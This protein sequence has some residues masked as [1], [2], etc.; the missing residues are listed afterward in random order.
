MREK[1]RSIVF[2]VIIAVF[3]L[4]YNFLTPFYAD[5]YTYC[6][7]FAT[8][9]RIDSV[10]DIFPSMFSH[11]F[12]ENGRLITHALVQLFLMWGKCVFNF[13]NTT[14]FIS[15][16]LVIYYHAFT[17][18]KNLRLS[19]LGFIYASL[20]LF[21]P[22]FGQSVLW[23][24]GAT[25]YLIGSLIALLFLIPY[26]KGLNQEKSRSTIFRRIVYIIL[27]FLF[28][29]IAGDTNE[30][31]AVCMV[32]MLIAYCL[33]RIK[34][35]KNIQGWAIGG[36]VGEIIGCFFLLMSPGSHSRTDDMGFNVINIL[37]RILLMSKDFML[38]MWPLI[39]LFLFVVVLYIVLFKR[40]NKIRFIKESEDIII[41]LLMFLF[42][43]YAFAGSPWFPG[44]AWSTFTGVFIILLVTSLRKCMELAPSKFFNRAI[45]GVSSLVFVITLFT[46]TYNLFCMDGLISVNKQF[47]E[48][49]R[50]ICEAKAKGNPDVYLERILTDNRY[51]CYREE[52]EIVEDYQGWPNA[53]LASY[54]G[55]ESIRLK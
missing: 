38:K 46:Y 47:N 28:G 37:K 17:T 13:I 32:A 12:H 11:Y 1:Q 45:I 31:M 6:F 2:F 27:M 42:S 40:N 51:S 41:Y 7:S 15:F 49:E 44:R 22:E 26:R 50:I 16:G 21:I 33:F 52:G 4:I 23:L 34:K 18:L 9:E 35:Y 55:V 5:D 19:V 3:I 36:L 39:L 8:W 24:D 43:F 48:R 54:Y 53:S 20:F 14:A 30:N 29:L 10:F 25:N